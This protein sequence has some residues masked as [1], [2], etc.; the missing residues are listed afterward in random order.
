MTPKILIACE[1]SQTVTKEFRRLGAHAFSCDILP[2][3]GGFSDWHIQ[4]DVAE[5]LKRPW[6]AIIA[7]P[8]CTHLAT[9]G[10]K[11]FEEKRVDGRQQQGIDF[12]LLFTK[13][14]CP[15]VAIENP[16]GIMSSIW[17]KPDQTIQPFQFGDPYRK[18]TC[19]WLK[20]LPRLV[21]TEIVNE[22]PVAE[23]PSGKKMP[24][25]YANASVKERA[26]VR[27]K[28]FPG[29]AKAMAEQWWK[30]I[31]GDK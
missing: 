6:D 19:L 21:P 28:T 12:F 15:F 16:V 25:W 17:R 1:E 10:A 31:K 27:S 7:F 30:V 11:W 26:K 4:D 14:D 8:P 9:S 3:S 5:H 29:V 13:V 20:N 22:G 18:R 24:L 23:Y 2:C